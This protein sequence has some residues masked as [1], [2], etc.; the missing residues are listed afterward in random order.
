MKTLLQ[1][2]IILI[3][4]VGL[5]QDSS[6]RICIPGI[7]VGVID[8]T[9]SESDL[10]RI[11][12]EE[13]I[14]RDS[15]YVGE[16]FYKLGTFLFPNTKNEIAISWKNK[17]NFSK[18]DWIWIRKPNTDWRTNMGITIGTKMKEIEKLNG[19]PFMIFGFGWDY[20][21]T[22]ADW[23]EGNLEKVHSRKNGLIL[24]LKNKNNYELSRSEFEE[25]L[26]DKV[27][28]TSNKTL[29]KLNPEVYDMI[30]TFR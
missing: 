9:T 27:I 20:S 10:I 19:K 8:S 21:G 30:I 16:G 29:Q 18:P 23:N 5:S 24:R 28:E 3:P 12:G 6:N 22:V 17:E 15:I 4:F 26:G 2:L 13:Q 11:F 14:K 25:V 7:Q 1:L